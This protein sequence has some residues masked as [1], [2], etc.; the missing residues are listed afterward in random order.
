MRPF[1]HY[2]SGVTSLMQEM[3][4]MLKIKQNEM[5]Q[6]WCNPLLRICYFFEIIVAYQTLDNC[7][8]SQEL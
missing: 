7:D 6:S 2:V 5:N 8:F 3:A 4:N 1:L